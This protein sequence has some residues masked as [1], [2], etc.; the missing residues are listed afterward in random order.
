MNAGD[1][2]I[3]GMYGHL[4]IIISN[5]A[6]DPQQVVIVN[7]TTY[8]I[9]EEFTCVLHKGEHPF[10]KHK[11][12]VR[13]RDA[14]AVA[15]A[16]LKKLLK[17]GKLTPHAHCSAGLLKKMRDGASAHSDLLPEACRALLDEQ[18]LI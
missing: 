7:L 13:Y 11:T 1:T 10:V 15:L 17:A 18:G 3:D 5:P 16:A 9:D 8:T 14:R 4:W 12:A 2:F 6:I